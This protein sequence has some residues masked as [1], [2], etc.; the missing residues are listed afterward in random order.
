[1]SHTMTIVIGIILF[2]L[3]TMLLYGIGLKR[4]ATEEKRLN[5]MLLNN[6]A[7]RVLKYL[8]NHDYV[9]KDEIGYIINDVKASEFHSKKT[10]VISDG[11]IF[12]DELAGFMLEK[13][14]ICEAKI[15]G[16]RVYVLPEYQG[17]GFC[18]FEGVKDD[19]KH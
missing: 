19:G 10:A 11:R 14:Y 12:Q 1:M 2:A 5:D 15:K 8:K 16:R 18:N 17:H 6:S 7:R 4:K 9:T 3:A 13:G